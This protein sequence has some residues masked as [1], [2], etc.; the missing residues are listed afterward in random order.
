M[1]SMPDQTRPDAV[2]TKTCP[3]RRSLNEVT[4]QAEPGARSHGNTTFQSRSGCWDSFADEYTTLHR[5]NSAPSVLKSS[6][7]SQFF[8]WVRIMHNEVH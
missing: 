2:Q 7:I 8:Q 1:M 5:I 6:R 3:I 4:K